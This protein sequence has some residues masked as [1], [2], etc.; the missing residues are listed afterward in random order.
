MTPEQIDL[1]KSSWAKV[2]PIADDAAKIFYSSLFE[3]DPSLKELFK[4]DMKAQGK[5]LMQMIGS[6]V[7]LLDKPDTLIPVVQQLGA[8]HGNYGVEDSHYPTVGGALIKTL[9]TGLG[10][11]F[12]DE[13]EKAWVAAYGL[14]SSTMIEA[15]KEATA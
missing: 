15:A 3:A 1:C 11:A 10:D 7:K 5:K 12:D 8:R 2:E 14:L 4:G 6:A 9:A 13:A